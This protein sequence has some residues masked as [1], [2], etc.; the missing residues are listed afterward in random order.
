MPCASTTRHFAAIQAYC[1]IC[2][3]EYL[4]D[5]DRMPC[6]RSDREFSWMSGPLKRE[7]QGRFPTCAAFVQQAGQQRSQTCLGAATSSGAFLPLYGSITSRRL[8]RSGS[9][10]HSR[11]VRTGRSRSAARRSAQALS[12]SAQPGLFMDDVV[13]TTRC[14]HAETPLPC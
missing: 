12:D 7:S 4:T 10:R 11:A 9:G 3:H 6:I 5:R 8:H 14:D 1:L 2:R 13:L